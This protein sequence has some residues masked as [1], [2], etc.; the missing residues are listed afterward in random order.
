MAKKQTLQT[1][2]KYTIQLTPEEI[3]ALMDS[4][5]DILSGQDKALLRRV[6]KALC[7]AG[8]RKAA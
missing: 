2:M 3:E 7:D 5:P 4:H 1:V 8:G 6:K